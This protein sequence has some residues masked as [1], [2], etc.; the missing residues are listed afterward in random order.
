MADDV[1]VLVMAAPRRGAVSDR[2]RAS[3]EASDIGTN[4][5]WHEHPA[6]VTV[7]AHYRA[8]MERARTAT[9]RLVLFLEDDALVNR[10]I[11]ENVTTWTDVADPRFGVGWL[12]NPGGAAFSI[13]DYIYGR[14][15]DGRG[16][17]LRRPSLHC[18]VGLLFRRDDLPELLRHVYSWRDALGGTLPHTDIAVSHAI[19]TMGRRI[20]VHVP[21]LVEHQFSPSLLGHH[22]HPRRHTSDGNFTLGWMR[23][24]KLRA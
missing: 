18:S 3:I 23:N 5:E 17:W 24:M 13:I 16:R 21:S 12:I 10:H 20:C 15:H 19:R 6:G 22:H 11:V 7:L 8:V 9:T 1:T 4:Y 14:R 2:C